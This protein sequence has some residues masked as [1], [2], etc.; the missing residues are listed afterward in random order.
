[1]L[2]PGAQYRPH[3]AGKRVEL[4]DQVS[5]ESFLWRLSLSNFQWRHLL[6]EYCPS[7]ARNPSQAPFAAIARLA[8]RGILAFDK[9]P[10]I[11][12]SAP[13]EFNAYSPSIDWV[14]GFATQ[15]TWSVFLK[16]IFFKKEEEKYS[17]YLIEG[18]SCDGKGTN[19][20]AE[21]YAHTYESWKME[22]FV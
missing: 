22:A 17:R 4:D 19:A 1:M 18:A 15:P 10:D 7:D 12:S 21:I 13:L 20:V 14:A 9:L 2:A 6:N 16:H 8:I 11:H 5:T 3:P